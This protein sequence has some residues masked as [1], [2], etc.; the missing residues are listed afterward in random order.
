M[1]VRR[2]GAIIAPGQPVIIID[3]QADPF[4]TPATQPGLTA[5]LTALAAHPPTTTPQPR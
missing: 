3:E 5:I 1:T 4:D 2:L